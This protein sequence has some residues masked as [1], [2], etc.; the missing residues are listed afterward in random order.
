[1]LE[2]RILVIC[3]Y[4]IRVVNRVLGAHAYSNL[5]IHIG[6]FCLMVE[7]VHGFFSLS[8]ELYYR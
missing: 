1:M 3:K 8:Q 7:H 2:I 4:S 6:F 5:N